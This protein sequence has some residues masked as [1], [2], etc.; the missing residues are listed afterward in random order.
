MRPL[1]NP[2][3]N[4]LSLHVIESKAKQHVIASEA[5]QPNAQGIFG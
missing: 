2:G 1:Q 5:K 3:K 4:T